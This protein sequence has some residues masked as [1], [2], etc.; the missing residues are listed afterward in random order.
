MKFWA[1]NCLLIISYD[2]VKTCDYVKFQI[3]FFYI[4]LNCLNN[5]LVDG[6]V[7]VRARAGADL[8]HRSGKTEIAKPDALK[9]LLSCKIM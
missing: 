4:C 9:T 8:K 7:R 2:L 3:I 6:R 5:F 1:F